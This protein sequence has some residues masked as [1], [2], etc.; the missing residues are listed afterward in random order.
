MLFV[1]LV[2]LDR[3]PEWDFTKA[4]MEAH[5]VRVR[6]PMLSAPDDGY[7]VDGKWNDMTHEEV[8]QAIKKV[9]AETRLI[10]RLAQWT[11]SARAS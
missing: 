2:H 3:G 7:G 5:V 9:Q 11:P 8:R 6:Y 1:D 10:I 4:F